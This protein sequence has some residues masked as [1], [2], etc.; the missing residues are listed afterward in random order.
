MF[1]S[2]LKLIGFILLAVFITFPFVRSYWLGIPLSPDDEM[3]MI[4]GAAGLIALVS[5]LHTETWKNAI[6]F[7]AIYFVSVNIVGFAYSGYLNLGI[8]SI[9]LGGLVGLFGYWMRISF[10]W[11]Y[12]LIRKVFYNGTKTTG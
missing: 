5:G 10:L 2:L 3:V 7:G 8:G 1:I 11:A 6:V 9:I 4:Q 12:H